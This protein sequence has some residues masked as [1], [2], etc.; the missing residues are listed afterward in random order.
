MKYLIV[1]VLF[2]FSNQALSIN[3]K[4]EIRKLR[5]SVE[6][7][8]GK[9]YLLCESVEAIDKGLARYKSFEKFL[10]R[11]KRQNEKKRGCYR[12][13]RPIGAWVVLETYRSANGQI[14][15]VLSLK[16]KSGK[17]MFYIDD[18]LSDNHW[19]VNVDSHK[20]NPLDCDFYNKYIVS[21]HVPEYI[22]GDHC[23]PFQI[24]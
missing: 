19:Y 15:P 8:Q 14:W 22:Y 13:E 20:V 17:K 23:I 21:N 6:E 12:I 4:D 10:G 5:E 11:I 1:C 2:L 3:L 16:L 24:R 9:Y 18:G 7:P